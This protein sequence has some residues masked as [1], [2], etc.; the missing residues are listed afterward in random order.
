[1]Q[2]IFQVQVRQEGKRFEVKRQKKYQ[3][4]LDFKYQML[5]DNTF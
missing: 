2:K 3:M 1:M 5:K 4:L